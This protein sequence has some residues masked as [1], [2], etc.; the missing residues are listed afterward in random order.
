MFQHSFRFSHK[1]F[2][3][4]QM[5]GFNIRQYNLKLRVISVLHIT[6]VHMDKGTRNKKRTKSE[7]FIYRG[8]VLLL[9]LR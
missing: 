2:F 3:P 5:I 1:S 7:V 9:F 6:L 4:V 8:H